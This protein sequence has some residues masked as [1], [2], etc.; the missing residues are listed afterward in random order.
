[1]GQ[2]RKRGADWDRILSPSVAS[3]AKRR[4]GVGQIRPGKPEDEDLVSIPS[5]KSSNCSKPDAPIPENN[6]VR[7]L[8]ASF[9][10]RV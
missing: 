4:D 1:M 3:D 7:L 6:P 9:R 2:H 5:K 8:H 10:V